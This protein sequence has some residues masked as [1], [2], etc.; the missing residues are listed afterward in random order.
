MLGLTRGDVA[1]AI[2]PHLDDETLG[3]GGTIHRLTRAGITVHVLA[4]LCRSGPMWG[5]H[6]DAELRVKEFHVA[7]DALGVS[8][9]T[10]AW[11]DDER[12]HAPNAHQRDLV[13]LIESGAELSLAA[14]RPELFL[15]PAAT[16][17]HQDHQAVHAACF[18]AARAGGSAKPTPRLV[19]GYAGPED[20]WTTAREAWTVYI[21]TTASW[22]AKQAALTAY[23]SQLREDTHPR[24]IA[25]IRAIDAAT[26]TA[27]GVG[28]AERFVP[29]RMAC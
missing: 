8:G 4:V 25:A 7:C 6:S 28:L 5:G 17:F 1:L 3:A 12:A 18:A 29:Y 16:A 27:I 24:S 21:D 14:L 15:I 19:L 22:S 11:T 13:T 2:A 26:G 10:L 9:R 20:A 23:A